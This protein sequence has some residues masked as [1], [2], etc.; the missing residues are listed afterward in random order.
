MK[1]RLLIMSTLVG[2][3]LLIPQVWGVDLKRADDLRDFND[4]FSI[5]EKQVRYNI[6]YKITNG[7]INDMNLDCISASL[8]LLISSEDSGVVK[9]DM[10]QRLLGDI[11]MVLVDGKEWDKLSITQNILTVNFPQNT[12]SIEIRGSYYITPDKYTGVCD[13]AHDPPSAYLLS[14]LKQFKS[15]ISP[16]NVICK[17]GLQ[18]VLKNWKGNWVCV[19]N[20]S[21][22]KLTLRNYIYHSFGSSGEEIP[23]TK[24]SNQT[25]PI[26]LTLFPVTPQNVTLP[27]TKTT[28]ERLWVKAA[29]LEQLNI[30]SYQTD[31]ETRE[32]FVNA[33]QKLQDKYL[34]QDSDT[35]V[36]EN[37]IEDISFDSKQRQVIILLDISD[38]LLGDNP[39]DE[40]SAIVSDIQGTVAVDV[41]VE[42]GKLTEITSHCPTRTSPCN[43]SKGGVQI[44]RQNSGGSGST[45]SFKAT[46]PTFGAG[47]VI[48]GH[49]AIAENNN[50]LQPKLG[51]VFG[52][53][54]KMGSSTCDCAFVKLAS[55]KTVDNTI[56]APEVGSTYP[57]GTRVAQSAQIPGTILNLSG[58]GS[59][60]KIGDIYD[61][62][63]TTG[64]VNIST[65]TGDSGGPL[66]KPLV[67]GNAD[68]YGEVTLQSGTRTIYEPWHH[69]KS[70]L[71]LTD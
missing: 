35:Y 60:V 5:T 71:G 59:G 49:E 54:K 64:R 46:H 47:F 65:I 55:G 45:M 50:I 17:E 41:I 36:G 31:P 43:P 24:I 2:L 66:Y 44:E 34:N 4:S 26:P 19:K 16:N 30:K 6:P 53:V 20:T 51:T 7:T 11:F 32:I 37:G 70:D 23:S 63:S 57:I 61:S 1:T 13:V 69:I 42:F 52:T 25:N 10:S 29:E 28:N 22:E 38:K 21:V 14:P 12:S 15:G 27:N 68:L 58:V 39:T 62:G 33:V 8:V 18:L 3:S 56:W 40:I 67:N 9:L 48:A